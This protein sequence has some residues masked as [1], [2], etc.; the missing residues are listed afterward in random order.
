MLLFWFV[1]TAIT[2]H[3]RLGGSNNR[4]LPS[5]N[6]EDKKFKIK[7]SAGLVPLRGKVLYQVIHLCDRHLLLVSSH[8]LPLYICVLIPSSYKDTGHIALEPTYRI[9]VIT[10]LKFLTPTMV[11]FRSTIC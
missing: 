11:T 2:K 1:R 10:S 4:N 7:V 5:H 6:F 3:H 9:S 8:G